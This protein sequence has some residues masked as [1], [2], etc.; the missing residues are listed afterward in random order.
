MPSQSFV[1]C[2]EQIGVNLDGQRCANG[3]CGP[4]K[5]SIKY[6]NPIV[7]LVHATNQTKCLAPNKHIISINENLNTFL[8]AILKCSMDNVI[9]SIFPFQILDK[10]QSLFRKIPKLQKFLSLSHCLIIRVIIDKH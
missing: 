8:V 2:A 7:S 6:P 9:S 4:I 5:I 1:F 10:S 3:K